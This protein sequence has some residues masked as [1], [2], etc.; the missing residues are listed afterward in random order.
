[1]TW[2]NFFFLCFSLSLSLSV[3][4]CMFTLFVSDWLIGE[5]SLSFLHRSYGLMVIFDMC[6]QYL[7]VNCD[8]IYMMLYIIHSLPLCC[9]HLPFWLFG[10]GSF[11]DFFVSSLLVYTMYMN[12]CIYV[13]VLIGSSSTHY[14][15]AHMFIE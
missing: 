10:G 11:Y 1:M 14:T 12:S 4:V 15:S 9:L 3:F 7:C 8:V 2:V 13:K 6:I 5:W